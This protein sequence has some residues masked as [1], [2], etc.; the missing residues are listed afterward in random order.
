MQTR[1]RIRV[2]RRSLW[3]ECGGVWL[4]VAH[5]EL[6]AIRAMLDVFRNSG[7]DDHGLFSTREGSKQGPAV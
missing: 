2:Q 7:S 3:G 6:D 1:D 5:D 4:S